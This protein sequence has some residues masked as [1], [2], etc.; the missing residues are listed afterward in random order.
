MRENPVP[1]EVV[2]AFDLDVVNVF[3]AQGFDGEDFVP[4]KIRNLGGVGRR[5]QKSVSKNIKEYAI[6]RAYEKFTC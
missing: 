3:K 1:D 5:R 2:R 4:E 6:L